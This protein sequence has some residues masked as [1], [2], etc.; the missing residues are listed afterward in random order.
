MAQLI[1]RNLDKGLVKL[2]KQRAAAEGR[3]AEETHRQILKN[4]LRTEG[5]GAHLLRI[6]NVGTDEDFARIPSPQREID[7]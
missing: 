4:A 7:R 6:P 2:L 3:S 5:L 1:V